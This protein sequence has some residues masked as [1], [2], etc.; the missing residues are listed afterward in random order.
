MQTQWKA[1]SPSSWQ[2]ESWTIRGEQR[3]RDEEGISLKMQCGD[4]VAE[5]W[6][7]AAFVFSSRLNI[8]F[9]FFFKLR[10]EGGGGA[11]Q[12]SV[13]CVLIRVAKQCDSWDNKQ[14]NV[15]FVINY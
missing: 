5:R 7:A 14:N 15:L 1:S 2:P 12:L 6:G 3:P 8:L 9:F 13:T 10:L 4:S 11:L